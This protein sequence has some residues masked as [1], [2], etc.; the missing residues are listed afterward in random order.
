METPM[1]TSPKRPWP[2]LSTWISYLTDRY[3]NRRFP[4][5]LP[6]YS[7]HLPDLCP[8]PLCRLLDPIHPGYLYRRIAP[9]QDPCCAPETMGWAGGHVL[10]R[11][12]T[13]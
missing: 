4:P 11:I 6:T 12:V 1:G 2:P 13:E 3:L 9:T 7:R 10:G 8:I 5:H